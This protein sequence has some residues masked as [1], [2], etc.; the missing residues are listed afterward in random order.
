MTTQILTTIIAADH[1]LSRF[2]VYSLIAYR[3]FGGRL[4]FNS[5]CD[6]GCVHGSASL[7]GFITEVHPLSGISG[8][9]E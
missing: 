3:Q 9:L 7:L 6:Q 4:H 1:L 8:A 2:K 5:C